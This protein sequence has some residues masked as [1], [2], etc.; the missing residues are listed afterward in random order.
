[1]QSNDNQLSHVSPVR[2]MKDLYGKDYKS[3]SKFLDVALQIGSLHCFSVMNTPIVEH[4]DVFVRSIGESSDIISKEIYEFTDKNGKRLCLRPE[5]TAAV[6]RAI[7]SEKLT[8]SMPLKLMYYGEMFRYDRP[9]KG[10]YRQFRQFG[11][12]HLGDKS[13]YNDANII[14]IAHTIFSKLNIKD[15][16]VNINSIGGLESRSKYILCIVDILSSKAKYLSVDSKNRLAKNPLRILDSKDK[17]DQEICASLPSILE[18]LSSDEMSYF[19]TVQNCLEICGIDYKIDKCL[20]R[21]LDYYT[22]TTFEIKKD[23]LAICG[24]GRYD[25]LL[26][27]FGGPNVSGVGCA[28][29]IERV[30]EYI[31][32]NIADNTCVAVIPVSDDDMPYAYRVF[33]VLNCDCKEFIHLGNIKKKLQR[34][35]KINCRVAVIIGESERCGNNVCVKWMGSGEQKIIDIDDLNSSVC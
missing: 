28:F 9:Q 11:L 21:G 32:V 2:G 19:E 15:I 23:G 24:G 22:D 34:A 20:V 14:L 4:L 6:M 33:N 18:Y 35:N 26:S 13:P 31:S 17:T 7:V 27:E 5:G 25:N 29:G 30:C 10:R 1:M 16:A 3:Y 12:E 8:Q